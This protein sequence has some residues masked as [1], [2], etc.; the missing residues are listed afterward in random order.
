[1][2]NTHPALARVHAIAQE[3]ALALSL[4]ELGDVI[5]TVVSFGDPD[6]N[7]W[8]SRTSESVSQSILEQYNNPTS[9]L[10]IQIL[11]HNVKPWFQ[12]NPH[13]HLNMMSGR[14]LARPAGGPMASQD[15]YES[16]TWK[17][18]PGVSGVVLWC[19]R[20]LKQED[21]DNIWHLVIPPV[22]TLLDDYEARYKLCGVTIVS[23][24]LRHVPKSLLSRTGV[25]SLIRS[26]LKTCLAHLD[27]P[28]SPQ[29]LR[30]AIAA[31]LSLTLLTTVPGEAVQ[32]DQ[33]CA[34]LGEG[35]IGGIWMYASDKSDVILASLD[36]LPPLLHALGVG[37]ARFLKAL[38]P[39][40]V[41]P[42]KADRLAAPQI[43]LQLSSL[44]VLDV[45]IVEC[46]PRIGGWK[47]VVIDGLGRCW[48]SLKDS[49]SDIPGSALGKQLRHTCELLRKAC[50]SVMEDEYRMLLASDPELFGDL[51]NRTPTTP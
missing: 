16:Q 40:L 48:V 21:Y 5:F 23:A 50:P 18:H 4:T 36:A 47:G 51:V 43:K 15:L 26:S 13:P 46:A 14:K 10:L 34:L 20:H 45:L 32:F 27:N 3:S 44:R 7:S 35:I 38:I 19:V 24:M 12:S 42:L 22:M 25:D 37:S 39:Q 28:E 17:D 11:T 1:M 29:L 33:L 2:D 9:A 31:S 49:G 8:V 30:S 6:T 41:H